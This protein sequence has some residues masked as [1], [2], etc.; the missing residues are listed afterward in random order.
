MFIQKIREKNVDEID[1]W[2]SKPLK[3]LRQGQSQ[4]FTEN[5]TIR[6]WVLIPIY[7]II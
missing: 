2:T 4:L 5:F 1:G 7:H 3:K 6:G